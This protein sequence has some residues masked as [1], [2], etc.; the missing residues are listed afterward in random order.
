MC[1]RNKGKVAKRL[2]LGPEPE[3]EDS[4]DDDYDSLI[5][6][7]AVWGDAR[8][9][10]GFDTCANS[11]V[12]PYMDSLENYRSESSAAI[13]GVGTESTA[14]AGSGLL[15]F[16]LRDQESNEIIEMEFP[17]A[18]HLPGTSQPLVACHRVH[19]MCRKKGWRSKSSQVCES[20]QLVIDTG[21][22]RFCF[23]MAPVKWHLLF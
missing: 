5:A 8:S 13:Q 18:V 16:G 11:H 22:S 4:D 17:K 21:Q 10:I 19:K 20:G 23:R 12:T 9:N 6:N 7:R 3:D 15:K 14:I 2:C 1:P